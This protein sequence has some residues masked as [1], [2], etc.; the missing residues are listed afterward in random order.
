MVGAVAAMM[1]EGEGGG[2]GSWQKKKI[3][4]IIILYNLSYYPML[5]QNKSKFATAKVLCVLQK[6]ITYTIVHLIC[7]LQFMTQKIKIEH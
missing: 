6:T 1:A 2:C 5:S 4:N 7:F 3:R